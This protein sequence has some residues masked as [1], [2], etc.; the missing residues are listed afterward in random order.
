MTEGTSPYLPVLKLDNV[1]RAQ[2][3]VAV[4]H[5][6][7]SPARYNDAFLVKELEKLRVGRPSTCASII[8]TLITSY[9][10][11]GQMLGEGRAV[12]ANA[13]VPSLMAFVVES[14]LRT[15]SP[16]FVDAILRRGWKRRL[17]RLLLGVRSGRR[18]WR[19]TTAARRGLPLV[20]SGRS[21]RLMRESSGRSSCLK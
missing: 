1:L 9:A 21:V 16:T 4:R 10:Y 8:G 11:R 17:M 3:V 2:D 18:I 7:Y 13:L 19:S 15:Q 6:K 14:V 5:E 12:S 20:W